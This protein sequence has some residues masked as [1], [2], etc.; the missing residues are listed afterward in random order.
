MTKRLIFSFYADDGFDENIANKLHF[1]CLRRY[2]N[3]FDEVTVCIMADDVENRD[4]IYRVRNEFLKIFNCKITF[5]TYPNSSLREAYVFENEITKKL[6][7]LDG[8]TFFAHNKGMTNV[9]NDICDKNSV[10]RW[11]FGMYFL[12]LEFMGEVEDEL[13]EDSKG[14]FYGSYLTEMSTIE[15]AAH[16]WYAGT[17][18]WLNGEK[19]DRY[20]GSN[21]IS[22]PP[23]NDRFYAE[24]YPGSICGWENGERLCTHLS[25][26]VYCRNLYINSYQTTK[27]LMDEGCEAKFNAA[28]KELKK[29]LLP[30]DYTILAYNFGT[31]EVLHEILEKQ[32]N[33]EYICVTDNP[34]LTSDTWDIVYDNKLD[35]LSPMEKVYFVRYNCFDYCSTNLCVKIDSSIEIKKSIDALIEEFESG[36]KR[37]AFMVHP[38]SSTVAEEYGTWTTERGLGTEE[39]LAMAEFAKERGYD[40]GFKGI[41]EVGFVVVKKD[42]DTLSFNNEMMRSISAFKERG[43]NIRVDQILFS[44][45]LNSGYRWLNVLPMSHSVIQSDILRWHVHGSNEFYCTIPVTS[46]YG[47][48]FNENVKLYNWQNE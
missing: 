46:D 21:G 16:M 40:E 41:Y 12:S 28:F 24:L 20:C 25:K 47:Y 5:K 38:K 26:M 6:G 13:S 14:L 30:Y 10:L 27:F 34:D 32:E 22:T 31:Y 43:V 33:V 48:C 29:G 7:R 36:D 15:N 11:V 35:G 4:L 42:Y 37:M 45:L 23:V 19:I 2:S 1:K 44:I 8:I 18:F 9:T 3:V 39:V 17:F